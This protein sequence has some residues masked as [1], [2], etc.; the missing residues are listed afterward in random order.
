M[1]TDAIILDVDGTLW[2]STEIVARA[3][4]KAIHE[5]GINDVDITADRLKSLFGKTM[6]EIADELLPETESKIRYQ[7]MD[8]CCEYE[9]AALANDPC[10]ICYDDV[11]RTVIELSKVTDV[12]IVSNCQSGYIELFLEK[13]NLGSYIKD[14]ECFGNTGNTKAENIRLVVERN[15]FESPIYV[16]DTLGDMQAAELAG[17]SFVWASYGFGSANRYLVKIDCFKEL[18]AGSLLKFRHKINV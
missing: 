17:V 11:I 3:W 13:T 7:I 12:C 5:S 1:K 9:H 4:N 15:A 16:G 8:R 14:F 2:D 18:L 10:Q 6:K